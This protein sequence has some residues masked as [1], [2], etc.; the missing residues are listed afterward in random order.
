MQCVIPGCQRTDA[1]SYLA[2]R[3]RKETTNAV[4]AP[5][6]PAYICDTHAVSGMR[7]TVTAEA[8]DTGQADI[9]INGVNRVTEIIQDP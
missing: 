9:T 2:L 7:I 6:I 5:N 8:T 1:T 4:F 3:L